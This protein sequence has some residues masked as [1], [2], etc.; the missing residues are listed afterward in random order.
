MPIGWAVIA[1]IAMIN[2]YHF[3]VAKEIEKEHIKYRVEGQTILWN[4][5]FN[6]LEQNNNQ[7]ITIK[8]RM[9]DGS[10]GVTAI[11]ILQNERQQRDLLA[12]TRQDIEHLRKTFPE[13]STGYPSGRI[14]CTSST[15][16]F[17]L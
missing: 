10:E 17:R 14:E 15:I 13:L 16:C 1:I 12:K 2:I 9:E 5:V 11:E 3:W 8:V 4:A 6:Q 7:V